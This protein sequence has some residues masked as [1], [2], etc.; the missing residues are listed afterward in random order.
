[1]SRAFRLI[2]LAAGAVAVAGLLSAPAG[3]A[4]TVVRNA[5]QARAAG[6]QP[7]TVPTSN[8]GNGYFSYPA[9]GNVSS[10][11]VTFTMPTFNCTH[12]GDSE[13]L[14]PG[15]WVYDSSGVL[16][17]FS[18]VEFNCNSGALFQGDVICVDS[19]A[20][21]DDSLAIAPGDRI[22][23][24]LFE[25][26][27]QTYAAVHDLT[28]GQLAAV[29]GAAVSND[30]TVFLGDAGPSIVSN[31]AVTKIPTYTQPIRFTKAQVNGLYLADWSPVHYYLKTGTALQ[32]KSTQLLGDG[33]AFTATFVH[34]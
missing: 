31:G 15:I 8:F 25:S 23:A 2:A 26:S 17:Q 1:M 7:N 22:V 20:S 28:T 34:S 21:C 11:S 12:S 13:W 16:S 5:T 18:G 30:Y 19:Y 14:S 9:A 24:S 6:V 33:D 29:T 3:A 27:T 10:A 32:E 4:P